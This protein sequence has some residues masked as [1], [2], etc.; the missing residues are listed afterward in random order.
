MP[1]VSPDSI[2][3]LGTCSWSTEDWRGTIYG[4]DTAKADFIAEYARSF[5]TVEVD[6]TFY[7]YVNNHYSGHAPADVQI[8]R[9]QLGLC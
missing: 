1:A 6:S 9:E 7:G 8:I 5:N 2:I 4:A 3:R